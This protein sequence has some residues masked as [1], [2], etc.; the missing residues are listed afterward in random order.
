MMMI[1]ITT[2]TTLTQDGAG[3][4]INRSELSGLEATSPQRR[5]EEGRKAPVQYGLL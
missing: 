3:V 1:M 2:R 4:P 5:M